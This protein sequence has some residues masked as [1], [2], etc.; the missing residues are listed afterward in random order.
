[1]GIAPGDDVENPVIHRTN[2]ACQVFAFLGGLPLK[3]QEIDDKLQSNS[4]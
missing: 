2:V 3:G 4:R 1:V